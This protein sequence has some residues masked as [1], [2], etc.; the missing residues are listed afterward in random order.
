[1]KDSILWQW[2][3]FILDLMSR[4][5]DK[6]HALSH[7]FKNQLF[8][9]DHLESLDLSPIYPGEEGKMTSLKHGYFNKES[10]DRAKE[11]LANG[12]RSVSISLQNR[13]KTYTKQDHCMVSLVLYK[14]R[15]YYEAT[16]FYRTTEIC[17]KFL[18]DLKFIH[19]EIMP[20]LGI[21]KY[22]LTIFFTQLTLSLIFLHT[23]F[24]MNPDLLDMIKKE[25]F[26]PYWR[27]ILDDYLLYINKMLERKERGNMLM[28]HWRHFQSFK[29]TKEFEKLYAILTR[30][31]LNARTNKL[32]NE[33]SP[34][35]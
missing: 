12:A 7:I 23:L 29:K 13:D 32:S 6:P 2:S 24:L 34:E 3:G 30:R 18:F 31:N 28:S 27:E 22:T 20:Y 10:L 5:K 17:R 35:S 1:M 25:S 21:E 8:K 26:N 14:E 16:V 15:K 33:D 4:E 9:L 19:E 11:R